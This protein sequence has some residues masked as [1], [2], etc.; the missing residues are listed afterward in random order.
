MR[1]R[2]PTS[3][4]L[5]FAGSA[6]VHVCLLG[7]LF[8][9]GRVAPVGAPAVAEAA[10]DAIALTAIDPSFAGADPLSA[11]IPVDVDPPDRAW[12]AR[13]ADRDNPVPLTTAPSDSDGRRRAAPA[14]DH[15]AN[16]GRPPE[17]AFRLDDSMLRSRL[18]DGASEAQ[19]ARTRT[20]RRPASPQAI[21]REPVVG[22]GD[23]VRTVTPRRAPAPA[24]ALALAGP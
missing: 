3:W 8:A 21:R 22:I 10:S 13:E 5:G 7:A 18:T 23:A 16:G 19:P 11:A 14:P 12:D 24:P 17:H 9:F 4:L 2:R 20:S 15:G 6:G 1:K